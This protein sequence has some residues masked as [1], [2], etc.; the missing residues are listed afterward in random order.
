M[1][2]C[3][4]AEVW[5][6]IIKIHSLFLLAYYLRVLVII[7]ELLICYCLS[8]DFNAPRPYY[9]LSHT[10]YKVSFAKCA[11][12]HTEFRDFFAFSLPAQTAQ[13]EI[14]QIQVPELTGTLLMQQ[15]G[16]QPGA[17]GYSAWLK[18]TFFKMGDALLSQSKV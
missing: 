7:I 11:C 6:A 16:L 4:Y 12:A 18:S 14:T 15:L 1:S 9:E 5:K 3:S 8:Q 2:L 13:S 10:K 17:F